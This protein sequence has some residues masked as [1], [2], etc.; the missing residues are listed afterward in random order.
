MSDAPLMTVEEIEAV[1]PS[2]WVLLADPELDDEGEILGGRV[3][4]H[5]HDY[6]ELE[7]RLIPTGRRWQRASF[8]PGSQ[9]ST[10]ETSF[11]VAV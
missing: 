2:E 11:D 4:A 7:S 3:V 6:G 8:S 10:P 1:Y 5:G 9:Q